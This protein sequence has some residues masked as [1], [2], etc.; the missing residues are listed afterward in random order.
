VSAITRLPARGPAAPGA[1]AGRALRHLGLL[2]LRDWLPP[3]LLLAALVGAWELWVRWYGT[4]P[5]VLPA[6]SRVWRAFLETRGTLPGHIRTT[7]TEAIVGLAFASVIG[8]VLAVFL[9]SFGLM[10]KVLYPILIVS[11]NIPMIV[12]APLLMIWFGFG[13]APKVIVVALFGFFPIV[14]AT[15]DGLLSADREMVGLVRSMGAN[16]LQVMRFVLLPSAVPSFFAGLKIASAY[17]VLGAV[18]GEWMGGSSGLG[19]YISRA[20]ASFRVDRV[21]VAVAVVVVVSIALFA[22]VHLAARLA[23]PWQYVRQQEEKE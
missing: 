17:A 3:L 19:I 1:A 12:L 13:M 20:Q 9:A 2:A 14:V 11:Q 7:M 18:V 22:A 6:P 23:S 16:R 15:A 8:V 10:R 4:Q 5:Y 21:F